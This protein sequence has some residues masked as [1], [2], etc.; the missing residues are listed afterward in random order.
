MRILRKRGEA[1]SN[2]QTMGGCSVLGTNDDVGETNANGCHVRK[3][4]IRLGTTRHVLE[5]ISHILLS[6]AK[7]INA[8]PTS[9]PMY[10]LF[11]MS[12]MPL[13]LICEFLLRQKMRQVMYL[14][15]FSVPDFDLHLPWIVVPQNTGFEYFMFESIVPDP[16]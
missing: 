7:S 1:C 13:T 14:R 3:F 5:R 12:V 10:L 9:N 8:L 6:C 16:S 2:L 4:L 15:N 11:I